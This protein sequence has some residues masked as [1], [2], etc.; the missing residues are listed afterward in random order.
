MIS[1]PAL[2]LVAGTLPVVAAGAE[3]LA[4]EFYERLF[5]ARPDLLRDQFNRAD[6]AT[7]RQARALAGTI[8][9]HA[10]RVVA[11]VLPVAGRA[12]T[13]SG[14][15][16]PLDAQALAELSAG[17]TGR[18]G[19]AGAGTS[20]DDEV[21]R[22]ALRHA[23]LG[24]ARGEYPVFGE[25]LV[26]ALRSVLGDD[27]TPAVVAAWQEVWADLADQLAD[28]VEAVQRAA[29]LDPDDPWREAIVTD[30]RLAAEDVVALT[31]VSADNEPLPG[32]AAGQFAS[33]QVE[34]PDGAR[35]VRQYSL[36]G[37]DD[38]QWRVSARVLPAA[39]GVPA[40]EV[41][42][43]L[44]G[45][46]EVGDV[47]RVSAPLGDL[48]LDRFGGDPLLLVSAG[49]GCTPVLGMLDRLVRSGSTR[50]V[51]V[52]HFERTPERHA[53]RA[54][55]EDLVGRLPGGVLRVSYTQGALSTPDDNGEYLDPVDVRSLAVGDRHRVFLCGPVPF[56]SIVRDALVD[57][58]LD[59]ARV[60]YFVFGPDDGSVTGPGARRRRR[61]ARWA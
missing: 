41:S 20:S 31:L 10:A 58:G 60:H 16:T 46:V 18:L 56:M 35:Q 38:E 36:R 25:H 22:L 4:A 1:S 49:I 19:S 34:L 12:G 17:A 55:L 26:A 42:T 14:T 37:G 27:A 47:V 33:L 48:V 53:H 11:P 9:E 50:P 44:L 6:H 23:A 13:T 43:H 61:E 57:A 28:R 15:G 8:V 30:K 24:V 54:E 29:D 51:T 45:A 5:T 59:P 21:A 39:P 52:L 3:R 7:G 2:R 40:G 32:Y